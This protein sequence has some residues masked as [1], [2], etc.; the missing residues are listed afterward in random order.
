MM[1]CWIIG[2]WAA[3]DEAARG[4]WVSLYP[5]RDLHGF[6]VWSASYLGRPKRLWRDTNYVL[7]KGGKL[8]ARRADGSVVTP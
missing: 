5:L 3:R 2:W 4:I 8:V 1:E 6:I 7:L